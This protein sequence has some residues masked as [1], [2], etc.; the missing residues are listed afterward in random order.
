MAAEYGLSDTCH[1]TMAAF[2]DYDNDGDLDMYLVVNQ[3]IDP[4]T[5]NYFHK[6]ARDGSFPSSGKLYRNDWNDSLKHPVFTDV[7]VKAGIAVEG[8]GH[9]VIITDINQDGWKDIFVTN[10]YLP[11][12]LL[13]INNH[14]GTFTDRLSEYMKHSSSNSMGSDINDINNDGLMDMVILDMNPEDNYRKKMMLNPGNYLT[15]QNSDF[16]GYNYQYVRNTLQLNQG[17]RVGQ[18]DSIGAP[19]FSEIGWLSGIAETDWSW[20][21]LLVDFDNDGFRD[22]IITNGFPKDV[23][24]HDFIAFRNTAYNLVS[25]QDL[26]KQIPEVKRHNYAY[27]NNGNLGFADVSVDWGLNVPTFSNG[28]AYADLDNDGALDLIVNN[29]NDEA[30]V[31]RNTSRDNN[32]GN[33]HFLDLAF[34]GDGKNRNGLGAMAEIHY[35]QG[36]KQVYENSPYRGY[37]STIENKAHFGLGKSNAV[38]TLIIKW[39]DGKMQVLN[40]VKADQVLTVKEADAGLSYSNDKDRFARSSLF[41]EISDSVGIHFTQEQRDYIDFNV[42]KLL[43]HKFSE[44]GPAL[45]AGDVDGNGLDDIICGG[46]GY[47]SAQIF[48]Q[49]PNG[50]FI[51]KSLISEEESKNKKAD[52]LGILLFDADGDGDLDLFVAHGG[53]GNEH[54]LPVYQDGLYVNNGKGVFVLDSL[55]LPA[56]YTSKFC[57]RAADFDHDGDLDLFI[58]GRVD[59]WNYPKPVSSFIYRNDSKP[60]QIRFTDV[61]A[62]V[63]KD[64]VNIGM[65]CDAIWT[66]F[67]NDGWPDLILAGEWMPICF[68]K[69]DHGNFKNITSS[70]GIA[71]NT[72]WWN[73]IVAGDFDNDGDI[74]YVVGNLGLNSFYRASE[75]YPA[76]AY[77]KDFDKNGIYD[78]ITSLYIP[79]QFGNKKEFPA[80]TRDDLIKQVN[81]M[82]KKFPTYKSFAEAD[83]NQVLTQEE[84]K[85]AV[86]LEANDFSSAFLRN[87]GN[88]NFTLVPLPV[89]AQFSVINGMQT[90]D[91]DGDGNLDVLINGN[92]FGTEVFTGRY[93]AM[94]GLLLKGDGKGGFIPLSILQSGIFIPG[95]GKALVSLKSAGGN[96]LIAASQNKGQL[97]V[98]TLKKSMNS[99]PLQ[100]GDAAA[101]IKD[102]SG[103]TERREFYYGSSFLSQSG[104]Y[105]WVNDKTA[106]IEI[107]DGQGKKRIIQTK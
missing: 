107:V 9:N 95:N 47:H 41:E 60:G 86:V 74:D 102:A 91:F 89:Q 78:L 90:G 83:M 43:P 104:R 70:S 84:R 5:P 51:Q 30:Q 76:H 66:D 2:F 6:L 7:S 54:N 101:T 55:A 32:I 62:T 96:F 15:Y 88:G 50:K 20:T 14:D 94:N 56:N 48:F 75:K 11:N 29:I 34:Q 63:A 80:E 82:R 3:I 105:L 38:D 18:R 27:R 103:K 35:D 33:E 72:G 8:Y 93:D 46:A 59:P 31:Y 40:H 68:L 17:P 23:T 71:K 106:S 100:R 25:K 42:Q 1:S 81:A 99:I 19:I 21:P 79:D 16:Y 87:D 44:Y 65:V 13:W 12:D 73:S 22:L 61:T 98:Y 85:G 77:G 10:D 26:L 69:N 24:D 52:D 39:P 36:K 49:Q 28:A 92:D 45:A 97:K 4:H 57:V 58:S 67:D 37:L 64:L 53:F